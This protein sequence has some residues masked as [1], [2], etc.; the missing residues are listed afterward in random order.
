MVNKLRAHWNSKYMQQI[1]QIQN[2]W[3]KTHRSER[4][5][6]KKITITVKD[7]NISLS[8]I[9]RTNRYKKILKGTKDL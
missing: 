9:Y 7:S 5:N 6:R 4:K 3:T 1:T 2:M 8:V